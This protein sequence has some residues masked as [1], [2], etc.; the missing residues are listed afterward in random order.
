M[1]EDEQRQLVLVAGRK[2]GDASNIAQISFLIEG[3]PA[4]RKMYE[5]VQANSITEISTWNHGD[6]WAF[7]FKD[8]EGNNIECYSHTPWHVSQP[9][10]RPLDFDLSDEE[11]RVQTA[12]AAHDHAV[13]AADAY[14]DEL[15]TP[16]SQA[17][18]GGLDEVLR[19]RDFV[20][21]PAARLIE[22]E[23]KPIDL[24]SRAFDLL[25]ALLRRRGEIVAKDDIIN[26]VWPSTVVCEGNLRFQMATLRRALGEAA[27]LIRT[28]PGRGYMLAIGRGEAP[29]PHLRSSLTPRVPTALVV[30]ADAETRR[31]LELMLRRSGVEVELFPS[32]GA[33]ELARNSHGGA[34]RL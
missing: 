19:L 15:L 12:S 4:L 18:L 34:A 2:S 27:Q 17:T 10:G 31:T 22:K 3:L 7:T 33:L 21:I 11:I 29:S 30:H 24:G 26:A 32:R 8:P 13:S 28:I 25:V 20:I 16:L 23:G 9:Y 14:Y 5:A 6:K 1:A